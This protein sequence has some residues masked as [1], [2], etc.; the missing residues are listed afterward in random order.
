MTTA[1]H[2]FDPV[3]PPLDAALLIAVAPP[4][5]GAAARAQARVVAGV[6]PV[7]PAVFAAHAVDTRL[8]AA[9]FL[10]QLAHESA[11]FR[12]T[13]EFASGAAYEG[14]R[15][16]GNTEPGDGRRYKGRGLIQLTGR[17][18]YR[19]YGRRLGV[20]LEGRPERAAEPALSLRIAGAYWSE[21][22]LNRPADRD[23]LIAITRAINGGLNGLA[24]RRRCLARAKR[25]LGMS[26][27]PSEAPA[28]S[29]RRGDRGEAVARLQRRLAALGHPIA[30]A[31]VFGPATE[32]A[33]RAV[34]RGL[35]LAAD[36]I[37]G[38]L[39]RA[40]LREESRV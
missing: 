31:A 39:T 4:L 35:G 11:G 30:I 34:Q 8:R 5:R 1:P 40:A 33:L 32:A 16:L 22:R 37:C 7:L 3:L 24:D 38:P 19:R 17:D 28:L 14:R 21:R 12:A 36:G 29:L 27:A 13:E 6:V 9:H 23:D 10:A 25:A 2:A 26:D 18:N 20:D 15:D